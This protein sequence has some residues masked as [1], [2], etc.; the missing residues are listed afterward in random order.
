M[1]I[2]ITTSESVEDKQKKVAVL[3]K[4][5]ANNMIKMIVRQHAKVLKNV[6]ENP[7]GLT[8]QQVF[9][10]LGTDAEEALTLSRDLVDFINARAPGSI[11]TS[12]LPSLTVNGDGT[13]TVGS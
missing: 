7:D 2:I 3:L 10:S 9:D 4:K 6:W 13:V 8:P 1:P 12:G 5:Y 11:D